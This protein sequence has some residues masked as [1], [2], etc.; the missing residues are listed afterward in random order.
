[1]DAAETARILLER[2]RQTP[3]RRAIASKRGALKDAIAGAVA[4]HAVPT[5][6][7]QRIANQLVLKCEVADLGDATTW[8]ALGQVLQREVEQLKVGVGLVDRQIVVALPKLSADQIA[9]FLE[10]L[11]AA[12]PTIARTILNV[13]LDAAEPLSAGRRYLAEYR[14][15]AEQLHASDPGVARTL[16]NAT[17][18]ARVP[19][20]KAKAHLKRFADLTK[21]FDGDVEFT[22][23]VAKAA[24]R[25]SDP[26]KAARRFIADYHA[27]VKALTSTGVEPHIARSLAG[28]AS[29]GADPIP[30]AH[31]LLQKFEDVLRL[32]QQ[33]HPWI[34]RSIALSA[35]RAAEPLSVARVYMQNYDAILR[36]ISQTDPQRAREVA[37]QAFRSDRP[38]RWASRYLAQLQETGS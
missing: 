35:C 17:F 7:A 37:A 31:T 14:R 13:A 15:V 22:R 5:R 10:E 30:T 9:T 12:D 36:V 34:A 4:S 26:L 33:T 27:V 19:R 6:L 18:M 2:V 32:V 20:R 16:A 24:F 38:L 29:I 23:T 25:A 8:R 3:M 21:A 28:M 1:M 11:Q